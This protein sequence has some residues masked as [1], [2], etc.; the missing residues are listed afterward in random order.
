MVSNSIVKSKFTRKPLGKRLKSSAENSHLVPEGLQGTA[1]LTSTL[2]DRYDG[3]E[4]F[5]NIGRDTLQKANAFLQG[6]S[7]IQFAVHSTFGNFLNKN[8]MSFV[9]VNINTRVNLPKPP[10]PPR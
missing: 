8:R 10:S 3:L 7:E 6:G 5:E 1:K 9:I 4:L 2:G